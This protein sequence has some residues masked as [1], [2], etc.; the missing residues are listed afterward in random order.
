MYFIAFV[1]FP[2]VLLLIVEFTTYS[3]VKV[4]GVFN[5]FL[6]PLDCKYCINPIQQII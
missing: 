2:E 6:I 1:V 4:V 5:V 3:L